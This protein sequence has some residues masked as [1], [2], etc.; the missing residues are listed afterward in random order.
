MANFI[1][2]RE[3]KQILLLQGGIRMTCH[4]DPALREKNL[5]LVAAMPRCSTGSEIL[6]FLPRISAIIAWPR[7]AG[8]GDFRLPRR[9]GLIKSGGSCHTTFLID[10]PRPGNQ[11]SA[12]PGLA[13]P[14]GD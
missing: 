2:R 6:R 14:V 12:I 8:I 11:Q 9:G 13:A 4:S 10:A 3:E 7:M 5:L 1:A